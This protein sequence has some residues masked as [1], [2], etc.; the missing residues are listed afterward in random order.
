MGVVYFC[1][2]ISCFILPQIKLT[3]K[4]YNICRKNAGLKICFAK[5]IKE[6][7]KI[8]FGEKTFGVSGCL[9]KN[10]A[11]CHCPYQEL[12]KVENLDLKN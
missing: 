9:T 4:R 10:L 3:L 2:F 11:V 5:V 12:R 1:D 8:Y 7:A 6:V